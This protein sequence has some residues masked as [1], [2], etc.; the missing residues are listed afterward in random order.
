MMKTLAAVTWLAYAW[1]APDPF[2]TLT[3]TDLVKILKF[4]GNT[5][6]PAIYDANVE[7]TRENVGLIPGAKLLSS[8]KSYDLATTLPSDKKAPLVFYCANTQCT[9]SHTAAKRA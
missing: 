3:I 6:T 7:S 5:F 9:A 2:K 1:S 8:S 4:S